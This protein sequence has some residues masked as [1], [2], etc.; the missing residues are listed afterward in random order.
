MAKA[1][2]HGTHAKRQR[3]L[4]EEGEVDIEEGEAD[5]SPVEKTASEMSEDSS[6]PLLKEFWVGT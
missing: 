5:I 4:A 1:R 2:P 3:Q 6:R